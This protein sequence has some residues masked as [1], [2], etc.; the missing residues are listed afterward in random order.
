MTET[1]SPINGKR[2]ERWLHEQ[3]D[4]PLRW[5]NPRHIILTADLF[6]DWVTD[7]M[8]GEIFA[9]MAVTPQHTY[10]VLT[11]RAERML[12]YTKTCWLN[13][14]AWP[15]PNVWLGVSVEDQKTADE[16]IPLLLETPAAVRFLSLEPLLGP[17]R[18]DQW[19]EV[20]LECSQC[21][22]RGWEDVAIPKYDE[23]E[24]QEFFCPKCS[25]ICAHT[26]LNELLGTGIHWVIVGGESGPDA[27]P[28][29]LYWVRSIRDQCRAAG[30]PFFFKQGSQANWPKF[31]DFDGFS[32]E[33]QMREFPNV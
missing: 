9:A 33:F 1:C 11:K 30:V 28:M 29:S 5:K 24:G 15:L 6:G 4:R 21:L 32:T 25:E 7:E 22:W 8:L 13:E 2:V 16:R 3:L 26:P 10:Q 23:I 31:K 27:R 14:L 12:E 18:L 17:V 20:G 19:T